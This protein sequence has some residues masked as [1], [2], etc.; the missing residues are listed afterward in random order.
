MKKWQRK[1][2]KAYKEQIQRQILS[3]S[4]KDIDSSSLFVDPLSSDSILFVKSDNPND[5]Q[6]ALNAY[7]NDVEFAYGYVCTSIF[8]LDVINWGKNNLRKDSYIYPAIFCFRM[9]LEITMKLIIRHLVNK[10]SLKQIIPGHGLLEKWQV[11]KSLIPDLNENEEIQAVD[12]IMNEYNQIDPEGTSFR[13]PKALNDVWKKNISYPG[14]MLIDV[15]KLKER[16]L[17]LYRFFENLY[18]YTSTS[19]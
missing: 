3:L 8:L 16:F 17:Q 18:D 13:Y 10:N 19:F 2:A 1:L 14:K 7:D 5:P 15:T 9:Y 11:L 4:T 6:L 12:I